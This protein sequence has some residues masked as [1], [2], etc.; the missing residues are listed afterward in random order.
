MSAI[1]SFLWAGIFAVEPEGKTGIYHRD[2]QVVDGLEGA[3]CVR[4]GRF[5]DGQSGRFSACAEPLAA[6]G[7]QSFE[8]ASIAMGGRAYRDPIERNY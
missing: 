6:S 2:E 7:T 8:R 5:S 3:A 1:A 4:L